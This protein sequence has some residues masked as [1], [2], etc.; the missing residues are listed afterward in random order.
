MKRLTLLYSLILFATTPGLTAQTPDFAPP[1]SAYIQG[2]SIDP[3]NPK[4]LWAATIGAGLY[5]SQDSGE[6][7]DPV[8][9]LESVQGMHAIEIDPNNANLLYAGGAKSGVWMS[10]DRGL[11]WR[12]IGLDS[13]SVCDIAVHPRDSRHLLILVTNGVY[14]CKNID[15]APWEHIF[16]YPAFLRQNL[17]DSE[18]RRYWRYSRFQ[19][20]EIDPHNPETVLIGGRWEGGYHRSDDGGDTWYH[21]TLGGIFRRADPI[22]FHPQDPNIIMVGTHH[23]GLFKSYNHGASWVSSS[24]G[25]EPQRRTPYYGAFLISGLVCAPSDN[26]VLYTGSDYSNWKSLDGGLSWHEV[27]KTL[28]CPFARAFAVDPQNADIVYAGT[29]VGIYKSVD[30]GQT[31]RF[32]SR[33]L[34]AVPIHTTVEL[35]LEDGSYQFALGRR[36]AHLFR[37][38]LDSTDGWLPINW[39]LPQ[40]LSLIEKG[41]G[42]NELRLVTETDVYVSHDGGLRWEDRDPQ[43]TDA[44]S[45][46]ERLPFSGNRNDREMWTVE[47]EL[48]GRAFFDDRW[49]GT[50][51]RRPPYIALYLV[52]SDYPIDNSL[53]FWQTTV[54]RALGYTIQIPRTDLPEQEAL[55]YCEVRDFQ[56]NTLTGYARVQPG[57]TGH[58]AIQ[59]GPDNRLPALQSFVKNPK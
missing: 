45:A 41:D 27:G 3:E 28:T 19:K 39:L 54:D 35:D 55:F 26:D 8:P 31:W 18:Q 48:E 6:N 56:R 11:S 17:P 36:G 42:A 53:P 59:L 12:H 58:I 30:G 22:L 49:V 10:T 51:Y 25:L 2:L 7:W 50:L 37:R 13:M 40:R 23:Q 47:I 1:T 34:P 38:S 24:I 15:N 5:V 52:T 20:I 4:Q 44:V 9:G 33:G 16:D 32:A 57:R 29:N 21:H 43:Y 46:V 14:R